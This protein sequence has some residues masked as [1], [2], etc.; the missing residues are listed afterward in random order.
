MTFLF[1]DVLGYQLQVYD[2]KICIALHG[3]CAPLLVLPKFA[4]STYKI[5]FFLQY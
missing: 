1:K 5:I 3:A 4:I 2:I